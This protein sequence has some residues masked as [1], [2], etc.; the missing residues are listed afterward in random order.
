MEKAKI[1]FFYNQIKTVIEGGREEYMKDIF[2]KYSLETKKEINNLYFLYNGN[3]ID[4]KL[5]LEEINK[6][7]AQLE[8]EIKILVH[9]IE[10]DDDKDY[11]KQSNQIICLKC[12]ELCKINFKD[13]KI[14]L[15]NC[16]NGHCF[17]N[18][19]LNEISNFKV[20][21]E[22]EIKC[23]NCQK[24]KSDSFGFFY[25]CNCKTNFCPLC[26]KKHDQQ[27]FIIKYESKEFLCKTMVKDI[28]Y[29]A[30]N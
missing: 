13:Y 18:L 19:L 24:S 23:H 26:K 5:K 10:D 6:K 17:S 9:D 20:I 30:K 7:K 8:D 4:E 27:H 22:K 16:P 21:N 14:I 28:F 11:I 15:N 2:Q 29:I 3:A 25:C 12:K 1:N